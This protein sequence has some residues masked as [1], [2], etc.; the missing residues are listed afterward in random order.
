[1]T[2]DECWNQFEAAWF[3]FVQKEFKDCE[4]AGMPY[5]EIAKHGVHASFQIPHYVNEDGSRCEPTKPEMHVP[6][7]IAIKMEV[8]ASRVHGRWPI[9]ERSRKRI[10][11]HVQRLKTK[12]KTFN[13]KATAPGL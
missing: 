1:M 9:P 2:R 13:E 11:A 8:E 4:K 7:S 5:E 10:E 3:K 12:A 6:A